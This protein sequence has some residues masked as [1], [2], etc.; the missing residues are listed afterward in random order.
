MT[1]A[2]MDNETMVAV[3]PESAPFYVKLVEQALQDYVDGTS[4]KTL[5]ETAQSII[6][7][8]SNPC[9]KIFDHKWL[10]PECVETGCQSLVW[11]SRYEAAVKGRQEFRQALRDERARHQ[12]GRTGAGEALRDAARLVFEAW[13]AH[14]VAVERMNAA[15]P[16]ILTATRAERE[17]YDERYRASEEAK[18]EWY[19]AMHRFIETPGLRQALKDTPV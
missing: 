1:Q 7:S 17:V 18:R 11:K 9:A 2:A 15:I 13:D 5:T 12:S 4:D 16:D 8:I 3:T 19:R 6:A 10:D 14:V